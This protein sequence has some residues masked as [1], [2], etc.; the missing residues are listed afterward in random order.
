MG[1]KFLRS[2]R[3]DEVGKVEASLGQHSTQTQNDATQN[4]QGKAS[5]LTGN[6]VA[7]GFILLAGLKDLNETPNN[8][9]S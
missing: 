1:L 7:A 2:S 4:Q 3:A 5:D 8:K 6:L 9:S